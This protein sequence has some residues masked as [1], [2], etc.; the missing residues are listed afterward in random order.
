MLLA[1]FSDPHLPAFARPRLRE[2]AGKRAIGF[3][4]WSLRR[5]HEH[6][7]ETLD[8]LLADV[9]ARKPDHVALTGDLVNIA[10]PGEFV[11]ARD[12]LSRVGPP[13]AVTFVPGNHDA[14]VRATIGHAEAQWSAYMSGDDGAGGFPFVRRR[15]GVVLVGLST[16]VPT[17][18][19]RATGTI[20]PAQLQRL[21]AMLGELD[22]GGAPVLLLMHHPPTPFPHDRHK[23][24]LDAEAFRRVVARH[25]V[26]AILHGHMHVDAL[27]WIEGERRV[28]VFGVPSASM[29]K[30]EEPAGYNLYGFSREAGGWRLDVSSRRLRN[31][32]MTAGERRDFRVR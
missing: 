29:A 1:H 30:G 14:Y 20:G 16:A 2:L 5:R 19:F 6:R 18:P 31:G 25:R 7:A 21:D 27:T 17:R 4:N 11:A 32:A 23:C 3:A 12:F 26:A 24:L 28:P 8:L 10:L 9:H 22:D 13:D 15:H